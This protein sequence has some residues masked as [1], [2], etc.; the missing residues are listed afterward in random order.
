MAAGEDMKVTADELI[1][2]LRC[3]ARVKK[4]EDD[5]SKCP[6]RY[7]QEIDPKYPIPHDIEEDGKLYWEQC[8]CEQMALDAADMIETMQRERDKHGRENKKNK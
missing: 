5:C 8:D 1:K 7:L 6:Y 2:A 4:E 3:S